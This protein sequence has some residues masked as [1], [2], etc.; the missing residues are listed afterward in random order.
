MWWHPFAQGKG[1]G[2][3]SLIYNE[4]LGLPIIIYVQ[5]SSH[6]MLSL[7]S[8]TYKTT[9]T[10]SSSRIQTHHNAAWVSFFVTESTQQQLVPAAQQNRAVL[11]SD[12]SFVTHSHLKNLLYLAM[13]LPAI[14]K[15]GTLEQWSNLPRPFKRPSLA[16]K[17]TNNK[18]SSN[19][20]LSDKFWCMYS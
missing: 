9:V 4:R 13:T 6:P 3:D 1:T 2:G 18:S 19:W 10:P 17:E 12:N 20:C 14:D 11:V 16:I 5:A 7:M 8:S 15:S